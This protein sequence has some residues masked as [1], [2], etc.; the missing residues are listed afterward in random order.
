MFGELMINSRTRIFIRIAIY[1]RMT[2]VLKEGVMA[3]MTVGGGFPQAG[4]VRIL[5]G[6]KNAE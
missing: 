1:L 4:Y 5:F 3:L 2:H 6:P